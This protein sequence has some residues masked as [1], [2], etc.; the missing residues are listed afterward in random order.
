M[1]E[2]HITIKEVILNNNC[3]ECYSTTG[4]QLTFKQKFIETSFY[5]SITKE[6][7]QDIE[8][9]TCNTK[10]YPVRWTKDMERGFGYHQKSF[11][12]KKASIKLKKKAWL[13]L[14]IIL[15]ILAIG[16]TLTVFPNL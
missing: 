13:L 11:E 14:I 3:P 16:I 8:C 4:L 2:K 1:I 15:I 5:K 9:K 12:S 10:I 7:T 6:T